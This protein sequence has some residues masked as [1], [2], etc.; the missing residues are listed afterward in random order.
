MFSFLILA[1]MIFNME[2]IEGNI[3]DI[4]QRRIYPG[5]IWLSEGRI[6]EIQENQKNYSTYLLPGF[7]DAHVH[8]ES[9]ML[10]PE[11][12]AKLIIPQGTLAIVND[13]HEIA[14]V[15]GKEGIYFMLESARKS[16]LKIFF[17][18]PSCVPA[19]SFDC[20]GNVISTSDV[21]ELAVSGDFKL[22]SEMMNVPGVLQEDPE[23]CR[24]IEI[25][26]NYNLP[27]DGHAPLLAGEELKKYIQAGITTDHECSNLQE[28]IEKIEAGM[29]IIIREGSAARNYEA[30]KELIRLYPDKVMF[31]TDDAHP[32]MILKKG[33]INNIVKKALADG[34]DFF[35]VIRI[36][37]YN[38]VQHYRLT[39]GTLQ[40]GDFADFM[41]I[42][43]LESFRVLE[44]YIAGKKIYEN[45]QFL[46]EKHFSD[47]ISRVFPNYF[48]HDLIEPKDL[49]KQIFK[50]TDVME[51]IDGEILTR[52]YVY[53]L[54]SEKINFE[55]DL[56]EDVLKIVYLNRYKNGKPQIAFVKGFGIKEG[57][58]A[59]SIAHDSHNILAVGC[60]DKEIT[61][62]INAL[63]S[64]KGG[65][66]VAKGG[67]TEC[68]SLPIAGIM[69]D[70]EGM[71]VAGQYEKL[72]ERLKEMG[73]SL[74]SPFMTLAF[75]SLLV[76]PELKIGEKGLFDFESFRFLED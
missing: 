37:C 69:S 58:F 67:K 22:L 76:I 49:V 72:N 39:V 54:P 24:K 14:N 26:R 10:T 46:G 42:E 66:V 55:S 21:E 18:I 9:S 53:D 19:T 52:K 8:I 45:G 23:V 3:V 75:M 6:M 71:E 65:L 61:D 32:D 25:A 15:C 44:A 47:T 50:Q 57:A 4:H 5:E 30:L 62:A 38:P 13:P 43:N 17:G 60:T 68:L 64:A 56:K 20:A 63:I 51:V 74:Q 2:K 41:R 29:K 1:S 59:S 12:F 36:A 34:Y 11:N 16:F 40:K 35:D 73:C 31:C 33:H 48:V 27:V 28:A 70:K 7:I